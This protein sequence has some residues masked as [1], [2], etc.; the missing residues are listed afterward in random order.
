MTEWEAVARLCIA[1]VFGA[2]IG[3]ERQARN[4]SAGLRTHILV[5][6]GSCVVMIL[7]INLYNSVQGLTNAD[8]ARLAAQVVNGIGFL[9]AGCILADKQQARVRG[10][11]SA[12]SL[13]VVAAI[14]LA[15]GAG[16]WVVAMATTA[17]VFITLTMLS[18]SPKNKKRTL[19]DKHAS[20]ETVTIVNQ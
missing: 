9:G 5:S 16:A 11:T 2:T 3:F 12:A 19:H 8:P 10:L 17:L 4:K 13:W 6:L 7:S 15:T 1:S 18:F 20:D 14:G